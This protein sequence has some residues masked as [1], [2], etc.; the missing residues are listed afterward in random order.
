[1]SQFENNMHTYAKMEIIY[2]EKSHHC[3]LP[4]EKSLEC[5]EFNICVLSSWK[6]YIVFKGL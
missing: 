2:V 5:L 6:L 4:C 1:M 3:F